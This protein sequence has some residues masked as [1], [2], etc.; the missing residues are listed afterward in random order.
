MPTVTKTKVSNR[1]LYIQLMDF[2]DET[3]Q[4]IFYKKIQDMIKES[5][6]RIKVY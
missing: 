5:K 6:G 3:E 2:K 4:D 1:F